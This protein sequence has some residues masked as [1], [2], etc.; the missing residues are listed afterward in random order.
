LEEVTAMPSRGDI[1]IYI[2]THRLRLGSIDDPGYIPI[3]CGKA[4]SNEDLADLAD[5][6]GDNISALNPYFSENTALYWMV[7]NADAKAP[8]MGLA[9]YRRYFSAEKVATIVEGY[10][11]AGS[12]DFTSLTTGETDLI[13]SEPLG[14]INAKTDTQTSLE[15]NYFG[16]H[17]GFD[18]YIARQAVEKLSPGYLNAFDFTMRNCHLVPFNVF[19]GR[20]SVVEEYAEWVFPILFLL[21]EWIPYRSYP[22][23]YQQ[24]AVG[25][26]A[27][28]LFTV[29]IVEN[30]HRY[31]IGFRPVL[32]CADP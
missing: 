30:R 32:K 17:I 18:L 31:K 8:Y 19:V 9:H 29:W 27:E 14:L 10:S 24:R 12:A 6:T 16:S 20:R 22:T 13:V 5:D 2:A 7:K 11:V 15:H 23:P 3:Q 25:F 4:L 1:K 21:N 26:L 28:R